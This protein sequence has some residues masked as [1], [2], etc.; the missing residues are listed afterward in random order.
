MNLKAD[1]SERNS[2][3]LRTRAT[4]GFASRF[5][6]DSLRGSPDNHFTG[7]DKGFTLSAAERGGRRRRDRSSS[8]SAAASYAAAVRSAGRGQRSG[9]FGHGGR[10]KSS[11]GSTVTQVS[12][13]Y[14]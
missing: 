14:T 12:T 5:T 13:S 11:A 1:A 10:E 3:V 6:G 9:N 8:Y 2:T 7:H 4:G